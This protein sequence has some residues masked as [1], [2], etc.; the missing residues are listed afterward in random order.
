MHC[1]KCGNTPVQFHHITYENLGRETIDDITPLCDQ[2]HQLTHNLIVK[3]PKPQY[4]DGL[5]PITKA[6]VQEQKI[7]RLIDN[8]RLINA[9]PLL[10]S[11]YS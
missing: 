11:L 1:S 9:S 4:Q 8:Q 5:A 7:N 2:C 3:M 6:R 10:K